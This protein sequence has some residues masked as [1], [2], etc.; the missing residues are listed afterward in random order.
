MRTL[1]IAIC[2]AGFLTLAACNRSAQNFAYTSDDANEDAALNAMRDSDNQAIG[3]G[4]VLAGMGGSG[5][6]Q[7]QPQPS[8]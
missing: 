8:Q 3:E 4:T 7:P 5:Q 6:Q 1:S 2:L